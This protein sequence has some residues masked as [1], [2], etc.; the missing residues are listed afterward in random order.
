M[1]RVVLDTNVLVSAVIMPWRN[2]SSILH[3]CLAQKGVRLCASEP[4]L[5][6]YREV[7]LRP[8]FGLDPDLVGALFRRIRSCAL[9]VSPEESMSFLVSDPDDAKFME[10]AVAAGARFLVTG[11]RKHFVVEKYGSTRVVTPAEFVQI[12]LK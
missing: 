11:N 2:P 6:E 7:L 8:K 1:I 10:C 9:V 12:F 4:V 5:K 3:L